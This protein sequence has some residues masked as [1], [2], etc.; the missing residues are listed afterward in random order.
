MPNGTGYDLVRQLRSTP[1]TR[2]L[3]AIALT[4]YARL[5]DRER[6]LAAGFNFHVGK[7]VD[8]MYLV[9]VVVASLG[10]E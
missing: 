10:R 9:R 2:D 1:H 4:A 5:E 6:A 3:P 7:P 8:P